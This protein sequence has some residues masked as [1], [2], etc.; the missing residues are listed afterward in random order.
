M[1]EEKH[2]KYFDLLMNID[3][4]KHTLEKFNK[5]R[6]AIIPPKVYRYRSCSHE[7]IEALKFNYVWL[8]HPS[9]FNDIYDC[10]CNI[11]SNLWL[12][13]RILNKHFYQDD[14]LNEEELYFVLEMIY[15]IK[16]GLT[17]IDFISRLKC[18]KNVNNKI[19][20][21]KSFISYENI[22][23]CFK[24][25]QFAKEQQDEIIINC[26]TACFSKTWKNILMWSHYAD[27]NKGFCI[28]YD[29]SIKNDFTSNLYPVIYLKKPP[30]CPQLI[31]AYNDGKIDISVSQA[32]FS[33]IKYIGWEY[34]EELRFFDNDNKKEMPNLPSCIYLGAN[35][36]K[37][38][39]NLL[40]EILR[41]K[42]IP[43]KKI[44]P[45][46]GKYELEDVEL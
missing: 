31:D 38:N 39:E 21:S 17:L 34:E 27:Y 4:T 16:N 14:T 11:N 10:T 1:N 33:T 3:G 13:D 36:T 12:L 19:T 5:C 32:L 2:K 15:E 25:S 42:N 28:E 43:C 8:S 30:F 26:K 37:D 40:L 44:K 46:L 23:E 24:N 22:Y 29:S 6:Y 45:V 7:N 35:I 18:N 41:A 9:L 20:N